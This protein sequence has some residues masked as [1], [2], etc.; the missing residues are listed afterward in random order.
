MNVFPLIIPFSL[1]AQAV[2]MTSCDLSGCAKPWDVH[3]EIVSVIFDEFY[4]EGDVE[5]N[6]RIQPAPMFDRD[7]AHLLPS[8]QVI[9]FILLPIAFLEALL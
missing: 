9:S 2:T 1:V 8:T 5:K 3:A 4:A 7:Q 6:M